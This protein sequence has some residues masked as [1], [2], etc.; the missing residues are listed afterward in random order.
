MFNSFPVERMG[1][2]FKFFKRTNIHACIL[3]HKIYISNL[4]NSLTNDTILGWSK[5]ADD[6]LK[7]AKKTEI[8]L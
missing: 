4:F 2:L 8:P 7:V 1:S 5:F 6:K 3:I